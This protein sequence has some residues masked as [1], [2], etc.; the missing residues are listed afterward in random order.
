MD[1]ETPFAQMIH[2]GRSA[3]K[4][5]RLFVPICCLC[6]LVRDESGHSVHGEHWVTRRAFLKTHSVK[7]GRLPAHSHLLS[8]VFHPANGNE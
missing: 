3:P 5:E 4:R 7:P 1:R 2:D 8:W 6:G